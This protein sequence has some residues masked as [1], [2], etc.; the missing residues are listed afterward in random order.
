MRALANDPAVAVV[1]AADGLLTTCPGMTKPL[2]LSLAWRATLPDAPAR[3]A[4]VAAV[5]REWVGRAI[6]GQQHRRAVGDWFSLAYPVVRLVAPAT[7]EPVDDVA[8]LVDRL[9]PPV[10]SYYT[11]QAAVAAATRAPTAVG[12][13]VV[14]ATVTHGGMR[15][16]A[17]R[18]WA[19][20]DGG[21]TLPAVEAWARLFTGDTG[22]AVSDADLSV[23]AAH[24][25]C[26]GPASVDRRRPTDA[27]AD[28]ARV[29]A[30][31]ERT[32]TADGGHDGARTGRLGAP[33]V[34]ARGAQCVRPRGRRDQ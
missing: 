33:P 20:R 30:Q 13:P 14:A 12:G 26:G 7:G 9:D 15:V 2:A 31:L 29:V 17:R 28:A 11:I 5:L 23:A 16:D 3:A 22:W 27:A 10:A 1:T 21:V 8:A 4:I 19:A 6:G 18:L 34:S 24:A 25:L 32:A